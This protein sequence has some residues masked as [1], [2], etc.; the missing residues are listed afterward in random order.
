LS[1]TGTARKKATPPCPCGYL[2]EARC[3]CTPDQL[4]RYRNR[5]SGPLLDRIDLMIDV[6]APTESEL[7]ARTL[8]E[9]SAVVRGR[10][11]EARQRQLHRQ[12]KTNAL[13]TV[14]D[15]DRH[16]VLQPAAAALLKQAMAR[17]KLSARAYH[18]VLKVARSIADLAGDEEITAPQTAEAIHYRRGFW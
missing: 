13:L 2:G 17:L 11:V 10:V 12:N 18:R 5:L 9:A 6:P 1:A 16:C 4:A 3:R 8:S 15:I 7:A 14:A